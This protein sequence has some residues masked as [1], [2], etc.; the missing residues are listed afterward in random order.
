M[1][2]PAGLLKRIYVNQTRLHNGDPTP[3][4]IETVNGNHHVAH[5]DIQG[6]TRVRYDPERPI[7]EPRVWLE[8]HAEVRCW[9]RIQP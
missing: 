8:T 5:C 1:I 3:I 9:Y 6:D 2:L 4:L 7:D